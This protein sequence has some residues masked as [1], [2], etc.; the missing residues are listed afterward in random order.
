MKLKLRIFALMAMLLCF[1]FQAN[2][3]V[4]KIGQAEYSTFGEALTAAGEMSGDVTVEVYD[5]V[6]LN[7]AFSGSYSS[8]NFVGKDTDA[9]IYLDVQGYITATGKKVSFTDLTLS[10]SQGGYITNAG[11]MNV[12]FGVYDVVEVVYTNCVFANGAYASSG[13]VT[14]TDC[15]FKMS[16]D[17]YGL[18]AYGDVDVTVDGCEFDNYRGIKM[19]AEGKAKTTELTVKNTDFSALG[20]EGEARYRSHM[21]RECSS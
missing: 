17:K 1:A 2:A 13:N 19:Y 5:K 20:G 6:T 16:W 21:R 15:T 7:T 18:W 4:A 12:A 10:K 11:F 9:E 8:I 3:Q 14:Y